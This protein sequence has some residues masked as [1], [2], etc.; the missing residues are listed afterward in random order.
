M[1]DFDRAENH[2][3]NIVCL[4]GKIWDLIKSDIEFEVKKFLNENK[5]GLRL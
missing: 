1:Y 5:K 2:T 4:K 3:D